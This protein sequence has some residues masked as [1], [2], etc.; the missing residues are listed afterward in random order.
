MNVSLLTKANIFLTLS[1]MFGYV[2]YRHG[3]SYRKYSQYSYFVKTGYVQF[4][5]SITHRP[6]HYGL[7]FH[8]FG[9]FRLLI[10]QVLQRRKQTQLLLLGINLF[11]PP[12]AFRAFEW[13]SQVFTYLFPYLIYP[14]NSITFCASIFTT[15]ALAFERHTAVCRP[16]HYRNV[17]A[18]NSVRKRTLW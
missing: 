12:R 16:I 6:F 14:L 7:Y 13:S 8:Y 9:H 5:Q 17:T 4:V 18:Q 10:Y 1:L 11:S 2:I 3:G 15:V